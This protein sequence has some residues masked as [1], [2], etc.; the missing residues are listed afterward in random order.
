MHTHTRSNTYSITSSLCTLTE[1]SFQQPALSSRRTEATMVLK[2]LR[3]RTP[4]RSAAL[5]GYWRAEERCGSCD[6]V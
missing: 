5:P 2:R 4:S 3:P 6:T 1:M